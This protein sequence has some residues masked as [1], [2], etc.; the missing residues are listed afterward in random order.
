MRTWAHQTKLFTQLLRT[1]IRARPVSLVCSIRQVL[2][3]GI[4]HIG[5]RGS[6]AIIGLVIRTREAIGE[7]DVSISWQGG[8]L[9]VYAGTFHDP[10]RAIPL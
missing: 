10:L 9:A 6:A 5:G 7:G 4:N 3:T 2:V 1:E 8:C